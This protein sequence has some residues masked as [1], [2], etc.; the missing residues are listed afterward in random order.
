[1]LGAAAQPAGSDAYTPGVLHGSRVTSRDAMIVAAFLVA[2]GAAAELARPFRGSSIAFDSQVAVLH[3]QRITGGQVLEM[4]VTTTSKP[5]LTVAYGLLHAIS[6]DWRAVAWAAILVFALGVAAASLLAW[7][8]AGPAAAGFAAVAL[9]GAGSLAFDVGH[10]LAMPWALAGWAAAGLAVTSDRPRHALAGVALLVAALARIETLVLVAAIG[11]ALAAVTAMGRSTPRRAWLTVVVPLAA[12][13]VMCIHDW[14]LARDPF[15]W[16]AV[17]ARY[18]VITDLAVLSPLE[19]ISLLV[20]RYAAL[21]GLALL[22]ALGVASLIRRRDHAAFGPIVA[23]LLGLGPAMAAF[24]VVLAL[25]GTFVSDRYAAPIDVAVVLAAAIGIAAIRLAPAEGS[26]SQPLP[27]RWRPL[28]TAV[29]GAIAAGVLVWPT[30]LLAPA[31]RSAVADNLA[32]AAD[33]GRVVPALDE[34]L[35]RRRAV[36]GVPR[37]AVPG[38]LGPRIAVDLAMPLTAIANTDAIDE[39]TLT[40]GL[41]I[42]HHRR[43]ERRPSLHSFL[44]IDAP[45]VI[46]GIRLE[47]IAADPERGWWIVVSR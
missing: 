5:V 39:D 45:A 37:L 46:R 21:G 3:W 12:L 11:L 41:V 2:L 18:S 17:A 34:V 1:M 30:G 15:L 24:L 33:L 35:A 38:T 13:P 28:G 4:F 25:R 14:L 23:G 20:S 8:V 26:S 32:S 47:P 42:F 22:A 16:L 40:P 27:A 36:E 44:E 7:R 19:V 10:A 31:L 43:A 6:G 9:A 29:I